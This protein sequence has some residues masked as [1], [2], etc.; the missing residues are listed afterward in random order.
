M[1]II[2]RVV[3]TY[4]NEYYLPIGSFVQSNKTLNKLKSHWLKT[5]VRAYCDSPDH[6]YV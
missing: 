3:T 1:N 5:F 4:S 2:S 6:K